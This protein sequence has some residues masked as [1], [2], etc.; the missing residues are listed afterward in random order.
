MPPHLVSLGGGNMARAIVLGVVAS[1]TTPP[2]AWTVA[3][4]DRAKWAPFAGAGVA[5]LERATPSNVPPGVPLL[6]AVKPQSLASVAHD[7]SGTAMDRLVISI[8]AGTSSAQIRD[9][10]RGA[11]AGPRVVRVMPN[12]PAQIAQGCA[13]LAP[14]P[15]ATDQDLAM[16]RRLFGAVCPVV[17]S[18]DESL[19]DAFT[20]VAG[21]G[22]AYLFLLAQAMRDGAGAI[23][24]A[25]DS[26]DRVVRQTLL[27]AAALFAREGAP[28]AE[29]LRAAVT[30]KGGTTEAA[31]AVLEDAGVR[32]A[33]V[34]ALHAARDRG[35]ELG[36]SR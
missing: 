27:G 32:E 11:G 17:E 15:G 20:A 26:A 28:D 36:G 25:P 33:M 34:R 23:G 18:I 8:L 4:P 12:T 31:I 24:F 13:A 35:R 30:S 22:P 10:L 5:C 16:V 7:L 6:L 1:G 2:G 29:S 3:E 14:G 21:S 9:A 19:M